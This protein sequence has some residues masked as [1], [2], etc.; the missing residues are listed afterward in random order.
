MLYPNNIEEKIGFDK[1][2]ELIKAECSGA[3]GASFVDKIRFSFKLD[4]I[5]KLN[6]QTA[7]FQQ[8]LI[9]ADGFPQGGYV[10]VE[11]ILRKIR[12]IGAFLLEDEAHDLKLSFITIGDVLKFFADEERKSA[13][14]QL[15]ELAESVDFDLNLIREIDLVV[16]ERGKIRN[17]ASPELARIRKQMQNREQGLRSKLDTLLKSFKKAGYTKDDASHTIRDGRLVI[18]VAAEYKR[19]IKGFVHDAS[20]TG[21]TVYLEPQE[22]LDMNN[23]VRELQLD[24]QQ[25]IVRILSRLTDKIRPHIESLKKANFFLGMMDFIRAKARFANKIDGIKP[26][27]VNEPMAEWYYATHPLLFLAHKEQ[28][29]KV[30]PQTILLEKDK[31]DFGNFRPKCRREIHCPE[32]RGFVAIYV[33]MRFASSCGRGFQSR[34]FQEYVH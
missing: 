23:E 14:P 12:I 3:F 20:A 6:A 32:N 26:E 22:V 21:Q 8:I 19:A 13:Y 27:I 29:K 25:E 30:I 31:Q 10:D 16:D 34:D 2:R 15:N 7:E 11:P 4:T 9:Q 18:P 24:E 28:G 33:S 1:V 17:N 5:D